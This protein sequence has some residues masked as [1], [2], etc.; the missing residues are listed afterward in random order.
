MATV[1]ECVRPRD[2]ARACQDAPR[3]DDKRPEDVVLTGQW[4]GRT[5]VPTLAESMLVLRRGG[6]AIVW[7]SRDSRA[8]SRPFGE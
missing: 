8:R 6:T 7:L 5:P 3:S 1:E 2:E 4:D